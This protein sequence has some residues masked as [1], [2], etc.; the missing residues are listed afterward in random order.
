MPRW[1]DD[2]IADALFR[3][4]RGAAR[5]GMFALAVAVAAGTGCAV[6]PRDFENENDRLRELVL[7]LRDQNE[8]LTAL[9]EQRLD[10]IEALEQ[11]AGRRGELHENIP[12]SEVP[13]FV[14]TKLTH[15]STPVDLDGDGQLD[16]VRLYVRTLDQHGNFIAIAATAVA[17]MVRVDPEVG[18]AELAR[19]ELTHA[20]WKDAY[21]SHLL[22]TYY[23]V[24]LPFAPS[25]RGAGAVRGK[26]TVTDAETGVRASADMRMLIEDRG[27]R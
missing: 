22:G 9:A 27:T 6:G 12:A 17:Q 20:Q 1:V 8:Q 24:D 4:R 13:R 23:R 19:R 15:R 11:E 16:A 10:Q 26:L 7:E 3:T 21:R 25:V 5:I 18:A 2:I 14:T